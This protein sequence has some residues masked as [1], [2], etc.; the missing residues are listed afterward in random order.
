MARRWGVP[1]ESEMAVDA[2]R[3]RR[4]PGRAAGRGG[5]RLG[6]AVPPYLPEDL[7]VEAASRL[8][9]TAAATGVDVAWLETALDAEFSPVRQRRADAGLGWLTASPDAL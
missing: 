6:S 5:W 4:G 1:S 8:R 7:A 2:G 3:G 9:S